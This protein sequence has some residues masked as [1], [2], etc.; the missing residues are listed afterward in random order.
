MAL[1]SKAFK[2]I[3]PANEIMTEWREQ[4]TTRSLLNNEW[5]KP[6]NLCILLFAYLLM[7]SFSATTYKMGS[8]KQG[9]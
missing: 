3:L 5:D 2:W 7:F 9:Q 8:L 1:W 4:Q 6:E